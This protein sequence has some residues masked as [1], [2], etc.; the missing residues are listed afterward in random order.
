MHKLFPCWGNETIQASGETALQCR[1]SQAPK[2]GGQG[3]HSSKGDRGEGKRKKV[4]GQARREEEKGV[5]KKE[6]RE[7]NRPGAG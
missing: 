2:E 6:G 5:K 4:C 7:R 3:S 1:S